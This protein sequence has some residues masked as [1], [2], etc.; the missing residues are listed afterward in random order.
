M[1]S[2]TPCLAVTVLL[3]LVIAGAS[4]AEDGP[5]YSE[6]GFYVL[7]QIGG[8]FFR[9]DVHVEYEAPDLVDKKIVTIIYD[10]EVNNKISYGLRVGH[11]WEKFAVELDGDYV[12]GTVNSFNVTLNGK[13]YPWTHRI[14][15]YLMVGMGISYVRPVLTDGFGVT[16]FGETVFAMR[17]GIGAEFYIT[18]HWYT[19]V[20]AIY[21]YVTGP[22]NRSEGASKFDQGYLGVRGGIG[23]RFF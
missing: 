22:A 1:M 8:A 17:A 15:P 6:A 4:S 16:Q 13:W 12:P 10:Q 19:D 23:Y 20:G 9:S 3:A 18:E 14:Q 5:D 11:R 21:H 7:P 2:R